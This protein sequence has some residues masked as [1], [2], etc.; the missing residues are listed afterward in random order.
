LFFRAFPQQSLHLVKA[1]ARPLEDLKN[2][3]IIASGQIGTAVVGKLGAAALSIPLTDTYQ[4]LQRNTADGL[5]FPVSALADFKLDEVTHYHIDA[6][7]GGGPGGFWMSK[8]KYQNLPPKA[9]KILDENSGE[10]ESR[11]AGIILDQMQESAQHQLESEPNHQVVKLS[12]QTEEKWKAKLD[13]LIAAWADTD[14]AHR[15]VVAAMRDLAAK[16]T[17]ER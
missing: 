12:P 13:P 3:K 11:R 16:F 7:L 10:V 17:S 15:K 9:R 4:A 8:A 6:P 1:P 2:L 14:D 5:N